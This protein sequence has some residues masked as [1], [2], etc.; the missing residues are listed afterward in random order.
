MDIFKSCPIGPD[1]GNIIC[2]QI[3]QS[4][5]GRKL[6]CDAIFTEAFKVDMKSKLTILFLLLFMN[7]SIVYYK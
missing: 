3:K 2:G 1:P 5:V 4:H 7:Y 6:S